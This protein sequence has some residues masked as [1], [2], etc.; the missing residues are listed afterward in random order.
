MTPPPVGTEVEVKGERGTV[1]AVRWPSSV[2]VEF[3]DRR[4]AVVY[5]WATG[6]NPD[7]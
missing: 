4:L 3:R 6:E 1:I 5:E 7:Q 2:L